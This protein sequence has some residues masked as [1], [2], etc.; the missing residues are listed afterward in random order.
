[1]ISS[2]S[3]GAPTL[4]VA[5]CHNGG[6]MGW[7]TSRLYDRL[8]GPAEEV[9]LRRWRREILAG[10]AG[11]VLEIGPGTGLNLPLYPPAVRQLMLAEPD[12]HMRARL[13]AKVPDAPVGAVDVVDAVASTIPEDDA[14]FDAVVCTFVLCSVPDQTAA[15]A[16]IRRVLRPG[17]TLAFLEHVAAEG[18]SSR[19]R[20]QRRVGPVWTVLSGGCHLTRRTGDAIAAAGF[21]V[22]RSA[23]RRIRPAPSIIGPALRGLA[24]RPE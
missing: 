11:R 23:S 3:D 9:C 2:G 17:G 7:L 14:A 21:E 16:E 20:W 12:R 8:M 22:T 24:L 5:A 4:P 19:L 13:E 1:M 18:P 15:L 10:L 6:S